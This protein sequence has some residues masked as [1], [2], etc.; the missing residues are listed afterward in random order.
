MMRSARELGLLLAVTACA[1]PAAAQPARETPSAD[2]GAAGGLLGFGGF[3]KGKGPVTV[4]SDRLEYDYKSNIVVYRGTV[5]VVQGD[6]KL[7]S[8]T[9]TITLADDERPAGNLGG[10][11]KDKKAEKAG[12]PTAT[13]AAAATPPTTVPAPAPAKPSPTGDARVREIVAQGSVRIDQGTRWA[14]GGRAV[15]DQSARTFILTDN[16][17]L[18]DG[19]NEVAGDRVVVFLDEDRSV[20]EGGRKRVKAVLYPDDDQKGGAAGA[21]ATKPGGGGRKKRA[22]TTAAGTTP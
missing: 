20:V 3:G 14:V 13:D 5:E 22:E 10:K 2:G 11:G 6:V 4:T 12:E 9:L 19:P 17:V 21:P 18:H 8:D 15:F 16:P 1:V 7:K